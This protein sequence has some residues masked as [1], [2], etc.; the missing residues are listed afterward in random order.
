MMKYYDPMFY[1]C[2]DKMPFGIR[3]ETN[4]KYEINGEILE[5]AVN[6]AI[7]RY[8]YF[9]VKT[10]EKDGN[11]ITVP[12]NLPIKVFKGTL[13]FP[14]GS[15]EVNGHILALSYSGNTINFYITHVITDGNGF[16]PFMK[17]VLYV[18][19]CKYLNTELSNE[20]IR[21]PDDPLLPDETGN[22][23]PE[24]LMEKAEP[25]YNVPNKDFF[26][27]TDGGYVT[28][29]IRTSY[30]F[31]A[32]M[33]D[34]MKFS[35]ENDASPCALFSS[36]MA[37][38]IRSVHPDETKDIVSA[39]SFNLRPGLGNRNSYRMLCNA[40]M[41][42]YPKRLDNAP[43]SKIC[44]CTRGSITLQ[45]QAENVLYYAQKKKEQLEEFLKISDIKTKK[46]ILSKTALKDS[47]DNTFSVSYVGAVDYGSL[48]EHI[49]SVRYFTDG[50]TY[51]TLF[52]EISSFNEWF[53][54]TL[55]Q[56]F[57]NDVYY[58]A[59]LNELKQ[60]DIE[61]EEDGSVPLGTPDIEL[62]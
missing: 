34:V 15:K 31:R 50:S 45:S 40:I 33:S 17:T 58:K 32:K 42:R 19:L 59:L 28:D 3:I 16:T 49:E 1:I 26:R 44:T 18:Y 25:F 38:A 51:R 5:Y 27:I 4:L 22:P 37:K 43:V 48:Q 35:H 57:S 13:E 23:Y 30:N 6:R 52:T 53:Y 47:T 39:V 56:G 7:K 36:I 10:E 61:Y 55:L 24:E 46:E 20:G 12:N 2:S 54:I 11:L 8:P 9:S 21:R 29:E 62:P 41:I 60:N 14:L